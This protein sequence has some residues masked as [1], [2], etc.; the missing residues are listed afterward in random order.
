MSKDEV[1]NQCG[2][3]APCEEVCVESPSMTISIKVA[4]SEVHKVGNVCY[5]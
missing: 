5:T 2:Y 3:I 1:N 4:Q